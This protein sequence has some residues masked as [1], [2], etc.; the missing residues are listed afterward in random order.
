MRIP[1]G[2]SRLPEGADGEFPFAPGPQPGAPLAWAGVGVA[3]GLGLGSGTWLRVFGL[4]GLA[5]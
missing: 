1:V 4:R 2:P 5:G 3:S